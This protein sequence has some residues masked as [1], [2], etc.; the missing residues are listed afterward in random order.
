[1]LTKQETLLNRGAGGE[2]W[3]KEIWENCS[4]ILLTFYVLW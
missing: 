1:M 3:G 4:A 2:Q